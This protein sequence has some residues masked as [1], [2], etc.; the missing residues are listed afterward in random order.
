MVDGLFFWIGKVVNRFIHTDG[1]RWLAGF[2]TPSM[3]D[4][5]KTQ[6]GN[7]YYE[8]LETT[9]HHLDSADMARGTNLG[10][11]AQ[12]GGHQCW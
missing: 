12:I 4:W 8:N 2:Y 1:V 3:P 5:A 7:N 10:K 9:M 6:S 11:F